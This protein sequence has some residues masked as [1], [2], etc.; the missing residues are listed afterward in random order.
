MKTIKDV[1]SVELKE[2]THGGQEHLNET[3]KDFI[4]DTKLSTN[5]SIKA[6]NR[7]LK[8]YGFLPL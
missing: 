1:L 7:E 4:N 2:E 6:L 3:V 8:L 5:D